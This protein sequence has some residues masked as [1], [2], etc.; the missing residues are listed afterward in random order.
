M[1][2][3]KH[4]SVLTFYLSFVAWTAQKQ[5]SRG[6]KLSTF[7]HVIDFHADKNY[8]VIFITMLSVYNH[9][10]I[11]ICFLYLQTLQTLHIDPLITPSHLFLFNHKL[12]LWRQ[13][14]R[15]FLKFFNVMWMWFWI[16]F[17]SIHYVLSEKS[18]N[19]FKAHF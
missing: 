5:M 11:I 19:L 7:I 13:W 12:W 14:W 4:S 8:Y 6:M 2:K 15:F 18:L 1:K 3:K 9:Q 17:I 10:K 16:H